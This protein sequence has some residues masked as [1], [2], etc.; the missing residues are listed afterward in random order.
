MIYILAGGCDS[1]G[2]KHTQTILSWFLV[3]F[4]LAE[5]DPLVYQSSLDFIQ[6]GW[7]SLHSK[8][9]GKLS[10]DVACDSG[11]SGNFEV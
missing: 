2:E 8:T 9:Q 10:M 4:Q 5:T 11:E 1:P 3:H 7:K 6:I